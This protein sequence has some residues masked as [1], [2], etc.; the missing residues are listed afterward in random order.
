MV[1]TETLETILSRNNSNYYPEPDSRVGKEGLNKQGN[2][3][4]SLHGKL[5]SEMFLTV[6]CGTSCISCSLRIIIFKSL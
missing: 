6:A 5:V 3:S 4:E 1:Q 2:M